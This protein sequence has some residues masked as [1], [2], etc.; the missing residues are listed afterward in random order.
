MEEK[1]VGTVVDTRVNTRTLKEFA[2]RAFGN[3][4]L[5]RQIILQ[6]PDQM[7]AL[8]FVIK[9]KIWLRLLAEE[10]VQNSRDI[11]PLNNRLVVRQ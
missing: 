8:E 2:N 10:R 1:E 5:V 3:Y 9:S 6:D 11:L 7:P 4:P